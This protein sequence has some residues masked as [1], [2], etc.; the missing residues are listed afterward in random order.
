MDDVEGVGL[1][2]FPLWAQ[3]NGN[4][5]NKSHNYVLSHMICASLIMHFEAFNLSVPAL[6]L[7]TYL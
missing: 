5:L 7:R 2:N 4:F 6:L 3:G 1:W